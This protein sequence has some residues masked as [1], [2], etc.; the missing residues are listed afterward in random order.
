MKRISQRE[1]VKRHLLAHGSITNVEAVNMKI[2]RLSE[3]IR[4]LQD[5]G[6]RVSGDWV[7]EDGKK[8]STYRYVLEERPAEKP[9]LVPQMV[10]KDGVMMVRM[11]PADA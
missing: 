4:E 1:R 3:R 7:R 5:L 11:V 10:E 8:T 6:L 2:L 9:K